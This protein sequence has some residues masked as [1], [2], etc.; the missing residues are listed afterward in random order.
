MA[1]DHP[2]T[3]L[4]LDG[5]ADN[6]L[7]M[8][9]IARF[10][11]PYGICVGALLGGLSVLIMNGLTALLGSEYM[12]SDLE[13]FMI[14]G[15]AFF[16]VV[17]GACIRVIYLLSDRRIPYAFV[18]AVTFGI[19]LPLYLITSYLAIIFKYGDLPI[20]VP[21]ASAGIVLFVLVMI[22][23]KRSKPP[24][25]FVPEV[26][27]F[28]A[29]AFLGVALMVIGVALREFLQRDGLVH[30]GMEVISTVGVAGAGACVGIVSG[31]ALRLIHRLSKQPIPYDRVTIVICAICLPIYTFESYRTLMH[32]SA[33][34]FNAVILAPIIVLAVLA[35][36]EWY[37]VRAR[38]RP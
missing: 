37:Q 31:A 20:G 24:I 9:P 33:T 11:E 6:H 28:F 16:G 2:P 25:I 29:G 32:K 23:S 22:E 5:D 3:K 38:R 8:T 34:L 12:F 17:F 4:P 21:G 36:M 27:G 7:R 15:G 13:I 18:T 14:L 19:C 1:Y 10:P 30:T 35:A 26:Y